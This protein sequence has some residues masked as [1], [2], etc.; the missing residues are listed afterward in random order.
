M[1]TFRYHCIALE[2]KPLFNMSH[3]N[4]IC[5]GELLILILASLFF[6]TGCEQEKCDSG[7]SLPPLVFVDSNYRST[8]TE[9]IKSGLSVQ[10]LKEGQATG[11]N[12]QPEWS[13][14]YDANTGQKIII[15]D[16]NEYGWRSADFNEQYYLLDWGEGSSDTLFVDVRE[17]NTPCLSFDYVAGTLNNKALRAHPV[18]TNCQY[19]I[20]RF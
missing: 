20:K 13:D 18:Y 2:I 8:M 6:L 7:V 10:L 11:E 19:V 14:F 12:I 16:L 9:E 3:L 17:K 5:R 15:L 4:K 1:D